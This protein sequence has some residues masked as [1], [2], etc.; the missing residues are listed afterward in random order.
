MIRVVHLFNVKKGIEEQS[1]IEWFDAR[2]N[3]KTREFGCVARRTWILLDGFE[4]TYRAPKPVVGRPKYVNEAYWS[5]QDGPAR[6]RDWLL[7][8]DDG[9]EFHDRWF[10]SICDHTILRYVEGWIP[11]VVGEE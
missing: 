7:S 4:G 6:F 3:E 2:L 8:S 10:N 11:A 9:R 5:D 1:F